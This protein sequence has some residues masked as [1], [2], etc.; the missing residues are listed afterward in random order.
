MAI[1]L[2][3]SEGYATSHFPRLSG[4]IPHLAAFTE[5]SFEFLTDGIKLRVARSL[6]LHRICSLKTSYRLNPADGR[7]LAQLP[8]GGRVDGPFMLDLR[9]AV[10]WSEEYYATSP[11]RDRARRTARA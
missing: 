1:L 4:H 10:P 8:N 11:E 6:D 5:V 3:S 9:A 2:V 7:D